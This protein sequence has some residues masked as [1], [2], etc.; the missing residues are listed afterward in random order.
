M[1]ITLGGAVGCLLALLTLLDGRPDYYEEVVTNMILIAGLLHIAAIIA[2]FFLLRLR[3]A[4]VRHRQAGPAVS[5]A[6]VA[7]SV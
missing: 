2:A 1:A 3:N 7:R 4:H 6:S 5:H